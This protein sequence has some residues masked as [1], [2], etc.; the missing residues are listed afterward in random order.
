MTDNGHDAPQSTSPPSSRPLSQDDWGST[1]E[2]G[3]G[4]DSI[5]GPTSAQYA[6]RSLGPRTSEAVT[7]K[8]V[9]VPT[10]PR[11]LPEIPKQL[12]S[13]EAP[14]NP[15]QAPETMTSQGLWAQPPH[16]SVSDSSP[17]L[18]VGDSS[19]FRVDFDATP[20]SQQ[21]LSNTVAIG[22][23]AEK[24][25]RLSGISHVRFEST[26]T[27]SG[28]G[29]RSEESKPVEPKRTSAT[30]GPRSSLPR[31][32]R[33][34]FRL[35]PLTIPPPVVD[36]DSASTS[37]VDFGVSSEP[38]TRGHSEHGSSSS[39]GASSQGSRRGAR[40]AQKRKTM[41][42][43]ESVYSDSHSIPAP[44]YHQISHPSQFPFFP[45]HAAPPLKKAASTFIHI[46][47]SHYPPSS[48]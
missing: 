3:G 20:I 21:R 13:P 12:P 35:T 30:R 9:P 5:L 8:E 36:S 48:T 32:P 26:E 44:P 17:M 37:Y 11:P 47:A 1:A 40:A 24:L 27:S 34:S 38:S 19:P 14:A 41:S 46:H 4:E 29:S 23:A 10:K 2:S 25:A 7:K 16:S 45:P 31:I 6:V 43:L 22:A 28:E 42:T 39:E 33:S 15:P 18:S